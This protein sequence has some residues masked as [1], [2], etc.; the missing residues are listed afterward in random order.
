[1]TKSNV[2]I[3][4]SLVNHTNA[5]SSNVSVRDLHYHYHLNFD[6]SVGWDW[7]YGQVKKCASKQ[8]LDLEI[9]KIRPSAD[10]TFEVDVREVDRRATVDEDESQSGLKEFE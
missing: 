10:H 9:W 6:E 2:V 4:A 5:D 1:M 8:E 3:G 7:L